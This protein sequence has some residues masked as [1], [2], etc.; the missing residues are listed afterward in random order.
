MCAW[1][2]ASACTLKGTS[3]PRNEA[4]FNSSVS[5]RSPSTQ[6]SSPLPG[7]RWWRGNESLCY[8]ESVELFPDPVL[9]LGNKNFCSYGSCRI[10]LTWPQNREGSRRW[11]LKSHF[12]L[13]L[14]QKKSIHWHL[15]P[16]KSSSDVHYPPWPHK[17]LLMK[18]RIDT[19][20]TAFWNS[21]NYRT[22]KI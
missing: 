22:H 9:K 18:F 16:I 17:K 15:L 14:I 5:W 3:C 12:V 2:C 7:L 19:T 6:L 11:P 20:L 10:Y 8:C 13:I 21:I 1:L 4:V